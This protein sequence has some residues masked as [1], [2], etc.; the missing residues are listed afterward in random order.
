MIFTSALLLFTWIV[1]CV[2]AVGI[3][4]LCLRCVAPSRRKLHGLYS[5]RLA[6]WWGFTSVVTVILTWNLVLPLKGAAFNVLAGVLILLAAVGWFTWRP[7]G[8]H[9]KGG[10]AVVTAVVSIVIAGFASAFLALGIPI[11]Y[12]TGLYHLGAINYAYEFGTVPGLANVHD[13]FGFNSSVFPLAASLNGGLWQGQGFRVVTGILPV[14]AGADL[15]LRLLSKDPTKQSRAGTTALALGLSAIWAYAL[16]TPGSS[17]ASPNS[18]IVAAL[19]VVVASAYLVDALDPRSG[20]AWMGATAIVVA[21]LAATTRPLNWLFLGLLALIAW[22]IAQHRQFSSSLSI[23]GTISILLFLLMMAR[24][25]LLSGYLLFPL[26]LAPMPVDWN[27]PT[28]EVTSDAITAWGRAPHESLE[29][30]LT[31]WEWFIPWLSRTA[32]DEIVIFAAIALLAFLVLLATGRVRKSRLFWAVAPSA[33][34]IPVWFATAPDPRFVWGQLLTLGTIPLAVAWTQRSSREAAIVASSALLVAAVLVTAAFGSYAT[35]IKDV[36]PSP[37]AIGGA[38]LHLK[39][40]PV[41]KSETRSTFLADGTAVI[42]SL[43]DQ[44][45]S[46]FPLCRPGG[47]PPTV[48]SRGSR[49][50]NGFRYVHS[51]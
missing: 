19:L 14:A 45:W 20:S 32:R 3:G 44:C 33:G 43:G 24:D 49:I 8:I 31:G 27:F 18:D 42:E 25:T 34:V 28:P 38:S 4:L 16:L 21:A 11:N 15:I 17:L 23:A 10:I 51:R 30:S 36:Q 50:N 22:G 26:S 40:G 37:V 1:V 41:I 2:I 12:D 48:V 29:Y 46:A 7:Q 13:R 39:L 6:L 9:G 47:S 5:L 35:V